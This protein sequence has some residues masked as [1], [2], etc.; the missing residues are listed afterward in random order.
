MSKI[1]LLDDIVERISK[2]P[3]QDFSLFGQK[4]FVQTRKGSYNLI[5][6]YIPGIP[7][8]QLKKDKS[9]IVP[10]LSDKYPSI[11]EQIPEMYKIHQIAPNITTFATNDVKP[12][13]RSSKDTHKIVSGLKFFDIKNIEIGKEVISTSNYFALNEQDLRNNFQNWEQVL[14]L[15]EQIDKNYSRD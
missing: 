9:Y 14:N 6:H 11:R 5:F 4:D 1:I 7:T 12:K 13:M 15:R 8:E 2:N 3:N 10:F